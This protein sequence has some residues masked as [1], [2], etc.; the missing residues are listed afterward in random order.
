MHV[1]QLKQRKKERLEMAVKNKPTEDKTKPHCYNDCVYLID[2]LTMCKV[3]RWRP[4]YSEDWQTEE[5]DR[6]IAQNG[7]VGYE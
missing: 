5:R 4:E 2:T 7:N 3:C 6:A 1:I